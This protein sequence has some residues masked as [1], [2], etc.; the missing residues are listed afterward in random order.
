MLYRLNDAYL[1]FTWIGPLISNAN[2]I[3]FFTTTDII[4]LLEV[5]EFNEAYSAVCTFNRKMKRSN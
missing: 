5:I 2:Y 4:Y 1:S 3:Y